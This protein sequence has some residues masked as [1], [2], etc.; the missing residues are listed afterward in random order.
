MLNFVLGAYLLAGR[1]LYHLQVEDIQNIPAAGACVIAFNHA[2][3]IIDGM[4]GAVLLRRRP[5]SFTF[6]GRGLPMEGRLGQRLARRRQAGRELPILGAY[7]ARG[8]SAGELLKAL[9]LLQAGRAV[10]LAAEGE[11]TW[12]GQLQ[13]PLA[14]GA[15]WMALRAHAPV[16]ALVSKGGYDIMP[17]WARLPKLSGRVSLRAGRPFYVSSQPAA[18]VTDEMIAAASQRIYD[19]MAA[20]IARPW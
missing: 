4:V 10:A 6:G 1:L 19:E 15:A 3:P 7:K 5:D 16:V 18:Q 9:H 11:L 17:R 2:A 20:L 8:L 12:D 14:P 13:H